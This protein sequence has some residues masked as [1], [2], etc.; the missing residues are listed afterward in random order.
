MKQA[1]ADQLYNC[2]TEAQQAAW[3]A[4]HLRKG[5]RVPDIGLWLGGVD[6]PMRVLRLAKVALRAEGHRVV[7]AVEPLRDAAGELHD[8]IA[9]R[10]FLPPSV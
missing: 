9:W 1:K 5:G 2:T 7:A 6:R 8:V 4:N 3:A 10:I